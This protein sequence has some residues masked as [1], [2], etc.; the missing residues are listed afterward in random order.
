MKRAWWSVREPAVVEGFGARLDGQVPMRVS[1]ASLRVAPEAGTKRAWWMPVLRIVRNA[2]IAAVAMAVIPVATVAVR[3][4]HLARMLYSSS[5]GIRG[6]VLVIA[7]PARAFGVARDPSITPMRVGLALNELQY[8][9][10]E[11][12]FLAIRPATRYVRPWRTGTLAADMFVGERSGFYDGPANQTIL[13]AV[14][15]GFTPR[16]QAYLKAL[17]EAPIWHEFDLVARAPAVDIV[18]G[19]LRIP[20]DPDALPEQRP[21]PSYRDNKEM[22]YAAV[23]RAAYYMSIGKP[24]EAE[25]TLRSIIS[26]GFALIDNGTMAM[27]ELIGTVDVGIGRDALRRFYVIEHDPRASLPGLAPLPKGP[28]QNPLRSSRQGDVA[29][30]SPDEV[31]RQLLARLAD[32]TRPRPERLRA[33]RELTLS[34]CTSVRG[35]LF[36]Q[37]DEVRDAIEHAKTSL[38]RYP[39]ERAVVELETRL[40]SA[41][42]VSSS[43]SPVQSLLV[44][45]SVVAGTVLGNPRLGAC[46]L[47]LTGWE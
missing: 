17:A 29:E 15:K 32:P 27:D 26:F 16:E 18:G 41:A 14:A 40:P 25:Q 21:L 33:V 1:G 20:F 8:R 43:A 38:A 45:P 42:I 23:S 11:N 22:A 7:E 34:Q 13:E 46:T 28:F 36:G 35:L 44:S 24:R 9:R 37:P 12:G 39:S 6:R 2:F 5:P 4:D 3:G 19:Q 30:L 47:L 10:S 31:R